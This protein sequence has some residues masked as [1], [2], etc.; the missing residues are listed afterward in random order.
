MTKPD[1]EAP[2]PEEQRKEIFL[3]IVDAQDHD[4]SVVQS[5]KLIAE[6]FGI[7]ERQL[8]QIEKDGM[9]NQWPPL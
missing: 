4:M 1:P 3:A 9:E 5:R 2:L 8:R 7:S 6:K